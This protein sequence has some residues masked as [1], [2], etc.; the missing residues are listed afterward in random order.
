MVRVP[1]GDLRTCHAEPHVNQRVRRGIGY[2]NFEQRRPLQLVRCVKGDGPGGRID[3]DGGDILPSHVRP[4]RQTGQVDFV[5]PPLR[6]QVARGLAHA[7]EK[8]CG[9]VLR[10]GGRR[11]GIDHRRRNDSGEGQARADVVISGRR[12]EADDLPGRPAVIIP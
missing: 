5:K 6:L 9:G 11:V 8:H 4:G 7:G 1:G 3:L 10:G 2:F 12:D